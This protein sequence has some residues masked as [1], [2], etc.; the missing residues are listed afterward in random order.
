MLLD[1]P[2]WWYR[3]APGAAA[4]ILQ[5]L[6]AVFGWAARARYYRSRPHRAR[7]PVICVGNFTAGGTGKTPL[8]L[9]LCEQLKAAGHEPVAL[10]R[11]LR[12]APHRS[13]LGERRHRPRSRRWR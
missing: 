6:G 11:E 5:P 13:L 4:K 3:E 10:T 8:A 7:F 2:S 9:Y 12:R 1:E